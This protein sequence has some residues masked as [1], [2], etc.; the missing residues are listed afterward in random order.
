MKRK[1]YCIIGERELRMGKCL[2]DIVVIIII[3][4]YVAL[5]PI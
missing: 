2:D 5:H 1:H 4:G 3:F